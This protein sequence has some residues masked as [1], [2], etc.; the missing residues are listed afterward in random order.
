MTE[1]VPLPRITFV[2][3]SGESLAVEAA[4]GDTVMQAARRTGIPGIRA[5]C[6]GYM[7]CG[8]CHVYLDDADAHCAAPSEW[9]ED[10]LQGVAAER[11]ANSRLACQLRINPESDLHVTIPERQL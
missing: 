6:G 7:K 10:M 9:E 1:D 11:R 5:E 4:P 8:T 2:D 3:Q